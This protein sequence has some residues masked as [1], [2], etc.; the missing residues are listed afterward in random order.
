MNQKGSSQFV[1]LIIILVLV[2]IGAYLVAKPV[3]QQN[4]LQACTLEGLICPDGS[5]VGRTG[6]NCEFAKCPVVKSSSNSDETQKWK[7]YINDE[8]GY[9]IKYPDFLIQGVGSSDNPLVDS[10]TDKNNSYAI[11]IYTY[12]DDVSFKNGIHL[13][14]NAKVKN[15]EEIMVGGQAAKKL[16]GIEVIS[17]K[18]TLIHVGP[19]KHSGKN[20]L[21]VYTSGNNG[22]E[23]E[24]LRILDQMLNSFKF[25]DSLTEAESITLVK[26]QYPEFNSYPSD[27]LPPTSIKSE[28]ANDGWY[29]AFIQNGSGI[30]IIEAKCFFVNADKQIS[31]VGE[32]KNKEFEMDISPQTCR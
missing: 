23:P 17:E 10:W 12:K 32:F 29:L 1:V 30:P 3:I 25:I 21:I 6:S 8:T 2:T 18:G 24:S 27:N 11:H 28:R 22:A 4:S 20:Y 5:T 16:T 26:K 19:V 13:E 14:F 9:S 31:L 15:D 7:T